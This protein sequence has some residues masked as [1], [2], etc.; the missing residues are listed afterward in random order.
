MSFDLANTEVRDILKACC[1][2]IEMCNVNFGGY[3]VVSVRRHIENCVARGSIQITCRFLSLLFF[4]SWTDTF[5]RKVVD[6][7]V[8]AL[9]KSYKIFIS[10]QY[11]RLQRT[12]NILNF[13][14]K[15]P[16]IICAVL[17]SLCGGSNTVTLEYEDQVKYIRISF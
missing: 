9:K 10:C 14:I 8:I 15:W 2:A 6:S 11:F 1:G 17:S 7:K 4:L 5:T 3:S 12:R 13:G 16:W